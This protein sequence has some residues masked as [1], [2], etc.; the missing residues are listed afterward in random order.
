[1]NKPTY[2]RQQLMNIVQNAYFAGHDH[3]VDVY[4]MISGERVSD[5][6][7]TLDIVVMAKNAVHNACGAVPVIRPNDDTGITRCELLDSFLL[8]CRKM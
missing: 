4:Y 2:T 3:L 8:R 5:F 7:M 1:M 6:V